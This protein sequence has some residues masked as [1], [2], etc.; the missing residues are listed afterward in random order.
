MSE[1]ITDQLF[2]AL[3]IVV[4]ELIEDGSFKVIGQIPDWLSQFEPDIASKRDGLTL[5]KFHFIANFL[6]DAEN[7]WNSSEPEPLISGIWIETDVSGNEYQFEATAIS[8]RD[9][10]ILLIELLK[11]AYQDKQLIVQKGRENRLIYERLVKEIQKKEILLH[12]I[13]HDL[14]GQISAVATSLELLSSENLTP[15]ARKFLEIG[16][17]QA[18]QQGM[19]IREILNA[20]SSDIES[21]ETFIFDP[22]LAPDLAIAVQQILDGFRP[23]FAISNI[24]LSLGSNIDSLE[25]SKVVGE[26]LHLDRVL[27]NLVE[28]AFRHSPPQTTV[29]LDVS[30]EGEFLLLTVED[31]GT[32]VSPDIAN[33]LFEKFVQGKGKT[34]RAGL[35]LYFCRITVESWGGTIG[36]TLRE[37]GGSRFWVRLRKAV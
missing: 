10:K 24:N 1:S 2:A 33:K 32:G 21:I 31:E 9:R 36:Y 17:S 30:D 29:T 34:G 5:E 13:V 14:G 37:S 4:L 22:N 20:F 28:N 6:I 7:Y 27:F 18:M 26:K 19:L 23:S 15:L 3:N 35:G 11:S 16:K 25:E 12:C 8:L